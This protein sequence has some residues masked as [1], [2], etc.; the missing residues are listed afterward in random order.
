MVLFFEINGFSVFKDIQI[1]KYKAN[2]R[3]FPEKNLT[4]K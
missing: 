4:E 2:R 1:K 3:L